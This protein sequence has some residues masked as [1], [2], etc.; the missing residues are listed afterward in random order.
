MKIN[1]ELIL[2]LRI[3]KLWSQDELAIASG[4]NL[5]TIQRIEKEASA[6]LQSRK[7]LASALDV[8]TL[9]LEYKELNIMKQYEYKTLDIKSNEGFLTGIKKQKLPDLAE[10]F[11]QEGKEGWLLVQILTPDLAQGIWSAKTGNMVAVLQREI[12]Q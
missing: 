6:S 3:K 5:R 8:D 11:N 10:I 2:E 4:L 12:L 7:A 9:E 1:A